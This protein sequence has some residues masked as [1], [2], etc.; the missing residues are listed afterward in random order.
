M[1]EST[2][3]DQYFREKA[4]RQR[5]RIIAAILVLT[6]LGCLYGVV[7]GALWD[8]CTRSFDREPASVIESYLVAFAEGNLGYAERCWAKYAYYDLAS[9]CS[10]ICMSRNIGGAFS[11]GPIEMGAE[12]EA[13]TSREQMVVMVSATCPSGLVEQGK[14]T[15]DSVLADVPWKHW[16]VIYSTVGG[17]I[18]EPWCEE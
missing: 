6:T 1:T 13:G 11:I 12:V 8:G 10:E 3:S 7:F 17:T 14:I 16:K 9:G 2:T 5:N 18:A 4:D 15:L